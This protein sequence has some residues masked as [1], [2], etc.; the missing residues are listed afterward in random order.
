MVREDERNG[1]F[2]LS[3]SYENVSGDPVKDNRLWPLD[4]LYPED[5]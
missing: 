4:H 2:D 5:Q 3:A 1:R